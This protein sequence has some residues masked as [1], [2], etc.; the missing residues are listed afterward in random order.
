MQ[1]RIVIPDHECQT[2]HYRM[3]STSGAFEDAQPRKGDLTVC[4]KCGTPSQFDEKLNMIPLTVEE[5]D[6]IH[7]ED[8]NAYLQLRKAQAA[9]DK[10]NKKN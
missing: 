5:L 1:D 10:M 6:K 3:D 9:I 8:R 4:L 7:R 2:C